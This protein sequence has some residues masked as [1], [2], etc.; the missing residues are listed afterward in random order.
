[1]RCTR[2]VVLL[3]STRKQLQ[4]TGSKAICKFESLSCL[5]PFPSQPR[6]FST[7]P[8]SST[9]SDVVVIGGG[10][11]GTSL[12]LN[13]GRRGHQVTV[14]DALPDV[15]R[16]STSYSSGI[17]RTMYM[18]IDNVKMAWEGYQYWKQWGDLVG[19][20]EDLAELR[21]TGALIL[22]NDMSK[23]FLDATVRLHK[24]L[25]IPIEEWSFE[26][27]SARFGASS[28]FN[29]DFSVFGPPKT[30][31]DPL[32]GVPCANGQQASGAVYFPKTGYV[33]DPT[34]AVENL[35]R[36]ANNT[37]NVTF[38]L[39]HTVSAVLQ[40]GGR[41]CGVT[42]ENGMDIEAPVVVNA[43]GPASNKITGMAFGND[44]SVA[45]D[46]AIS[47]RPVRQEVAYVRAPP[48]VDYDAHG[49]IMV[50]L[51]VGVYC[52]PE[53]GNRILIGSVEP[54]CDAVQFLDDAAAANPSLT[55]EAHTAHI[56][57]L[58]L[59]MPDLQISGAANTQGIVACYDVTE[60]WTPI[61]DHSAL[62]GYYMA[63]GTSGN[64]FKMA[65]V[66]GVMMADIIEHVENGNC[67]DTAPVQFQLTKLP[68]WD[69]INTA[70]YSRLRQLQNTSASVLC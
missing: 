66:V 26:E 57:R 7:G 64:Q 58:A 38:K 31:D 49:P 53:V 33:S 14:L 43:A 45:N 22:R 44:S 48:G 52:R 2:P 30:L 55:E 69:P 65:G 50:D 46:M 51:D 41:V 68:S 63:I 9:C 8:E 23:T 29:L 20:T 60:D 3:R 21:E 62:P 25:G 16:G 39:G 34:L 35:K 70:S 12:A 24:Q 4:N 61:Y 67:Q 40:R 28:P 42:C 54:S 11:I 37:G 18:S 1:M 15:G 56:M 36:A 17:C 32:F 19:F 47:T 59:R 10:V 13:L 27:V 5:G 6:Y